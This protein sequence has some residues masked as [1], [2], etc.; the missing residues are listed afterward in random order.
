MRRFWEDSTT[1]GMEK[2][3][4]GLAYSMENPGTVLAIAAILGVL[5]YSLYNYKAVARLIKT[6]AKKLGSFVYSCV[7]GVTSTTVSLVSQLLTLIGIDAIRRGMKP[8]HRNFCRGLAKWTKEKVPL[9]EL[10]DTFT[11]LIVQ[12]RPADTQQLVT[13][14]PKV[15][16]PQYIKE[17]PPTQRQSGKVSVTVTGK[18]I[19][20]EKV[21]N[22][23][24]IVNQKVEMQT[25]V[26][27]TTIIV[28]VKLPG[29]NQVTIESINTVEALPGVKLPPESSSIPQTQKPL[30]P[31][32]EA[33][34]TIKLEAE[35][36]KK[37]LD[38]PVTD[39]V[40]TQLVTPA[41]PWYVLRE[42]METS[43]RSED[44]VLMQ[45]IKDLSGQYPTEYQA[46]LAFLFG[47]YG[48]T[49]AFFNLYPVKGEEVSPHFLRFYRAMVHAYFPRHPDTLKPLDQERL[50]NVAKHLFDEYKS[51][52]QPELKLQPLV[53]MKLMEV[54]LELGRCLVPNCPQYNA[55]RGA[56]S[57]FDELMDSRYE[58]MQKASTPR[59]VFLGKKPVKMGDI[60]RCLK[61]SESNLAIFAVNLRFLDPPKTPVLAKY[62]PSSKTATFVMNL[63]ESYR[64][65]PAYQNPCIMKGENS[66]PME[67]DKTWEEVVGAKDIDSVTKED[68]VRALI[69][70]VFGI[71][72]DDQPHANFHKLVLKDAININLAKYCNKRNRKPV[73]VA[74]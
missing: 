15:I 2:A 34:I 53:N 33:I 17:V 1:W 35:P 5:V 49:G 45:K 23:T 9:K 48:W 24:E 44:R 47:Q 69:Y 31:E 4:S 39:M 55:C 36:P 22:I 65:G 16:P 46:R 13:A 60:H 62:S 41:A 66:M 56:M 40:A 19:S 54:Y 12:H 58:Q 10:K 67:P 68:L 52:A 29:K 42:F 59:L 6:A 30:D 43:G 74:S 25:R 61:A 18:S 70:L 50:R 21:R 64:Q 63:F 14:L 3:N 51:A 28:P 71:H 38:K 32:K 57:Y 7:Y 73:A 8:V 72:P 27:A 11:L 26:N 37:V 20:P